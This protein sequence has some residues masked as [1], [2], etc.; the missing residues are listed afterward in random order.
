M[1][2]GIYFDGQTTRR[3]PVEIAMKKRVLG[4][5]GDGLLQQ[6]RLSKLAISERLEDAPR[7]IYFPDGGCV[8]IKDRKLNALLAANGYREPRVVE[9]QMNWLRSLFA[10]VSLVVVL[11]SGYQWGLPWA[12]DQVAQHLPRSLE[13]KIG[14]GELA[15]IDKEMMA[16]SRLDTADQERLRKLFGD[17]R[18]PN[19]DR[20]AYRLEFRHSNVGPNAFALPNGVIIMTDELV[21]LARN[22]QAVL[23]VLGHELGHLYR[24]HALRHTLQALGVAAV[25]NFWMGDVSSALTVLPTFML[26]QK[27][28][29]DFEREADQYGIDMMHANGVPL[30]PMAAL[31]EK[32]H[33]VA[34]AQDDKRKSVRTDEDDEN[35][36]DED[37]DRSGKKKTRRA[38]PEY[39]SSHPADDER[40][41]RLRAADRK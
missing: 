28:S 32:M 29:R 37:Q 2:K 20:T 36:E 35:D 13:E 12:A 27:Y 41:A 23:G 9:W 1:I 17:L 26:D 6:H 14:E 31:F 19:G 7:I 39:F 8:H 30:S 3:L 33:T 38:M 10:L 11:V 25:M 18:Q 24:R 4:I 40:I 16:P 34:E 15:L 22:D 5:R 21:M